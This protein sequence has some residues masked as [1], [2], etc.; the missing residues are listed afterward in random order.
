MYGDINFAPYYMHS[1]L[2][3]KCQ[4][5]GPSFASNLKKNRVGFKEIRTNLREKEKIRLYKILFFSY[6]IR[7]VICIIMS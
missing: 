5:F 1:V 2:E 3:M 6:F 4:T 7:L